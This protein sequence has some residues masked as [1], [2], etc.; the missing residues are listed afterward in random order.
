MDLKKRGSLTAKG[1]FENEQKIVDK[2]LDY[3]QDL[4]AQNWLKIM[5]YDFKKINYLLA[6]QIP[7][8]LSK[9]KAIQ[10]GVSEKG[11]EETKSFKKSDVQ[12]KIEIEIEKVIYRENISIKKA[13]KTAGFNQVD[14][15]PVNQYEKYWNIPENIIKSLKYFTGVY[16]PYKNSKSKKRMFLD[17]LNPEEVNCLIDFFTKNKV[18][19]FNDVLR[20]RGALS[21]S[22]ML[23]TQKEGEKFS[24]I[25]KDMNYVCN[26]Y[27]QGEVKV[28]PKGSLKIG[29]M[30]MQ[31]KGGTPD[32]TSLQFKIN[33]LELFSS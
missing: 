2:F 6:T 3:K 12:I 20:G 9:E 5:G 28:S 10:L 25:L 33:P 4:D 24:Y 17:E 13:N 31:R 19:I 30:T 21:A 32:P 29:R 26:F 22:W 16:P 11:F 7:P 14:K 27:S 23:V 1:G 15:R 8:S 18:L